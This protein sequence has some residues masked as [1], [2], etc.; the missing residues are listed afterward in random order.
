MAAFGQKY[1]IFT[2]Q[3][4]GIDHWPAMNVE[5]GLKI[6]YF[7]PLAFFIQ[8]FVWF[9]KKQNAQF[10]LRLLLLEDWKRKIF[11]SSSVSINA[12]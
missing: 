8:Y 7:H 5:K 10:L 6:K 4:Y 1:V 9:E 12:E 2:S 3:I 11:I